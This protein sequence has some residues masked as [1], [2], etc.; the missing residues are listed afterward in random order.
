MRFL[1]D[2]GISPRT[3]DFLRQMDHDAVH[4]RQLNMQRAT[5]DVVADR[6]RTE[7]RIVLTFDL[8]FG[9]LLALGILDRPSVIIFR[10]TD[11]RP[12]SVNA[13][14]GP[15]LAERAVELESGAL[16]LPLRHL[17]WNRQRDLAVRRRVLRD[18]REGPTAR[19][20]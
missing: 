5:D 14:L 9:E 4:I 20:N 11:E 8:D 6:A 2:G 10:L 1:A 13:R 15:V 12:E 7:S 16:I 19:S 3:V 17:A 18:T